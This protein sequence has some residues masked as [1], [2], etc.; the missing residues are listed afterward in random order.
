MWWAIDPLIWANILDIQQHMTK[1]WWSSGVP[2]WMSVDLFIRQRV[3]L[4]GQWKWNN[5]NSI[6][7]GFGGKESGITNIPTLGSVQYNWWCVLQCAGIAKCD[8]R[9]DN[10]RW[11][12]MYITVCKMKC[13][14]ML[15]INFYLCV[16]V[17]MPQLIPKYD[18]NWDGMAI[19]L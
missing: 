11:K 4:F 2:W 18:R 1:S 13:I 12:Q 10:H 8:V 7:K 6:N 17:A 5:G 9:I 19:N 14:E 3:E 15:G 16:N